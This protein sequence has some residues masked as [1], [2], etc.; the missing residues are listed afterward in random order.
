MPY[1][2]KCL[3]AVLNL[4]LTDLKSSSEKKEKNENLPDKRPEI[5]FPQ[6]CV[7]LDSGSRL[8][9]GSVGLGGFGSAPG[10]RPRLGCSVRAGTATPRRRLGL[11][12]G[13]GPRRRF[14]FAPAGRAALGA[15]PR[16]GPGATGAISASGARATPAAGTAVPPAPGTATGKH[17]NGHQ[18]RSK[19]N[20]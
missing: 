17:N 6:A 5:T 13:P 19:L 11:R 18:K 2:S 14:G 20:L 3:L 16:V 7:Y 1:L 12:P 8:L 9:G 4:K 10:P 15:R